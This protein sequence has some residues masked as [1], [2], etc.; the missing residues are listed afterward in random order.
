MTTKTGL[1]AMTIKDIDP[2]IYRKFK[3]ACV[4][5]E[6]EIRQAILDFMKDYPK[7]KK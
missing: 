7:S 2:K 4:E 1:K 3:V 6:I 5:N